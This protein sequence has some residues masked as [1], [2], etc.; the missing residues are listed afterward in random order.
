MASTSQNAQ[1]LPPFVSV[2]ATDYVAL[3]PA[4]MPD[5]NIRRVVSPWLADLLET[6]SETS[7]P[8]G[9]VD[10]AYYPAI[11]S[12][13]ALATAA[14]IR[15]ALPTS[16]VLDDLIVG[17]YVSTGTARAP[18]P[19]VESA[20][21][22]ALAAA[23]TT[24]MALNGPVFGSGFDNGNRMW[25]PA[26][27]RALEEMRAALIVKLKARMSVR[28]IKAMAPER[29]TTWPAICAALD[30]GV[31]ADVRAT[32]SV[33]RI[34]SADM[35]APAAAQSLL[36]TLLKPYVRLALLASV[37]LD[38]DSSFYDRR[39]AEWLVHFHMLRAITALTSARQVN[40]HVWPS[41]DPAVS[42]VNAYYNT[43]RFYESGEFYSAATG[44]AT[45]GAPV[46]SV[47][48]RNRVAT[49]Y[50][51]VVIRMSSPTSVHVSA[52]RVVR[53]PYQPANTFDERLP[54]E[55]VLAARTAEGA[56]W[57]FVAVARGAPDANGVAVF[58]FTPYEGTYTQYAAIVTRIGLTDNH[59][60]RTRL[61]YTS[62]AFEGFVDAPMNSMVAAGAKLRAA[63]VQAYNPGGM[64]QRRMDDMYAQTSAASAEAARSLSDVAAVS[65]DITA[66]E[67]RVP[68]HEHTLQRTQAMLARARTETF[69]WAA[70]ALAVMGSLAAVATAAKPPTTLQVAC[71]GVLA[72]LTVP[73][74]VLVAIRDK[75]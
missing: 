21:E 25:H 15:T 26:E 56:Q 40:T 71:F 28:A 64:S 43:A 50:T 38:P 66:K 12:M 49:D 34:T 16:T 24:W 61:N 60:Q 63:I 65:E 33:S 55:V 36:A 58:A 3:A 48:T 7:D 17:T 70:A 59:V 14:P 67:R 69:T 35:V 23:W 18:L 47:L 10:L 6:T 73:A 11:T 41:T 53:R 19:T 20:N 1:A 32:V 52:L 44:L 29:L 22:C 72:A 27:S 57:E 62:A 30:E 13:Q 4:P 5:G 42:F 74:G 75:I 68:S 8:I 37:Q 31:F 45:R 2:G 9:L 46:T 54:S 51:G 39:V